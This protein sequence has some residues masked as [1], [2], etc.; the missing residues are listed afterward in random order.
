MS[1]DIEEYTKFY[2]HYNES[3]EWYHYDTTRNDYEAQLW[4]ELNRNEITLKMLGDVCRGEKVLDLGAAHWVEKHLISQLGVPVVTLDIAPTSEARD[5]IKADACDAPFADKSFDVIICRELIEHVIDADKLMQEIQ[6]LLVDGGYLFIS[7][8]NAFDLPPDGV[9]HRR[10]YTP[11]SFLDVLEG[12]NF[13][14]IDKRGNA[15]NIFPSLMGLAKEG[16]KWA[17]PEFKEIA[18]IMERVS[19]SYYLGTN[20]FVLAQKEGK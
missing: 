20:L 6:R 19:D 4:F 9:A 1:S 13:R 5:M 7:T 16:F 3:A 8:P 2:E 17:V 12:F 10:G 15:P 18:E 11:R 14:V